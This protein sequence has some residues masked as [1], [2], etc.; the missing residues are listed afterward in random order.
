MVIDSDTAHFLTR[1][2]MAAGFLTAMFFCA[3]SRNRGLVLFYIVAVIETYTKFRYPLHDWA[4][5]VLL[6]SVPVDISKQEIQSVLVLTLA[7]TTV[8]AIIWLIRKFRRYAWP[9]LMMVMGALGTLFMCAIEMISP[10]RIDAFIYKIDG[11][12]LRSGLIY[13]AMSLTTVAGA[14]YARKRASAHLSQYR[15]KRQR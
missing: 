4:R 12:F 5:D 10:H 7:I 14:F 1:L 2:L 6:A 9:Q 13:T 3:Q 8:V 15:P 11:F